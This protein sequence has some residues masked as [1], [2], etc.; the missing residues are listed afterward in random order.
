MSHRACILPAHILAGDGRVGLNICVASGGARDIS[1]ALET[2][3]RP[4]APRGVFT[5]LR[6]LMDIRSRFQDYE[7]QPAH[8][9]RKS[10]ISAR[11]A[12]RGAGGRRPRFRRA[13]VK[14]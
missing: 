13:L 4:I 1:G 3:S 9:A 2:V 11:N 14:R 5:P 6:V 8:T 7:K 12:N 10:E